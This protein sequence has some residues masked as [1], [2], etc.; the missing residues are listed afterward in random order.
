M[1]PPTLRPMAGQANVDPPGWTGL[2]APYLAH[3]LRAV[4]TGPGADAEPAVAHLAAELLVAMA[5]VGAADA[6]AWAL[7]TRPGAE[8]VYEV[9]S[10][11]SGSL[12]PADRYGTADPGA[13]LLE[14]RDRSLEAGRTVELVSRDEA[15]MQRCVLT[16]GQAGLRFRFPEFACLDAPGVGEG[17]IAVAVE[18]WRAALRPA[19]PPVAPPPPVGPPPSPSAIA[20]AVLE[21]LVADGRALRTHD[22]A[23][24]LAALVPTAA[25]VADLVVARLVAHFEGAAVPA[26][27]DP[28]A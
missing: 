28:E 6:A 10:F 25:D 11:V 12:D 4:L 22:V 2:P 5:E 20:D 16:Q 21:R 7:T 24:A 26:G 15:G 14:L 3:L 9:R 17:P 18:H 19:A 23:D 1:A 8:A 27:A 13:A